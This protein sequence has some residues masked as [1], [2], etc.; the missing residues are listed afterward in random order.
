MPFSVSLDGREK[1]APSADDFLEAQ[2]VQNKGR[3]TGE[4]IHLLWLRIRHLHLLGKEMSIKELP[5]RPSTTQQLET[6][7]SGPGLHT[8]KRTAKGWARRGRHQ[9]LLQL[10]HKHALI[11]IFGLRNPKQPD[12]IWFQRDALVGHCLWPTGCG[13]LMGTLYLCSLRLGQQRC[14]LRWG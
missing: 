5:K 10:T 7:C 1:L 13:P 3:P 11:Q 2:R 9:S 4:G 14:L 6:S 8:R 12:L